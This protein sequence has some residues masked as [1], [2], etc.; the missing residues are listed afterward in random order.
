M[1]VC[2]YMCVFLFMYFIFEMSNFVVK[3]FYEACLIISLGNVD[4]LKMTEKYL[5]RVWWTYNVFIFNK[6]GDEH[7]NITM[8]LCCS[9]T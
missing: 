8:N 5:K 4:V 9:G 7:T 2:I 1:Y 3:K 6:R